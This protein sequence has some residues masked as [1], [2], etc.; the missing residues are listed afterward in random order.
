MTKQQEVLVVVAE[1]VQCGHEIYL[2]NSFYRT[3]L[4]RVH[5]DCMDDLVE[6]EL[7]AEL[8]EG[9]EGLLD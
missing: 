7:G 4:G 3:N 8:V 5:E 1:C 6:A 2:H 9:F